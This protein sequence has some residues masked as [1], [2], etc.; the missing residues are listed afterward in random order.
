M[1]FYDAIKGRRSIRGFK[2]DPV[3]K[4]SVA[5]LAEA[6]SLAP[7]ACNI[8]PVK[9][10]FITN[11]DLKEKICNVYTREWLKQAPAIAVALVDSSSAWQRVE[12]DTIADVDGAIVM[13]NRVLAATPEGLGSCWICA[14]DRKR[15]DIAL[16]LK[17]PWHAFSITPLGYPDSAPR[18][19]KRK[20][21][22]DTFEEIP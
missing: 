10:L 12:G 2:P 15:M 1:D 18:E 16:G 6:V 20:K 21:T 11:P 22:A 14:F 19:L 3:P 4:D 7:S 17:A 8:Q 9:V 13:E 5:R